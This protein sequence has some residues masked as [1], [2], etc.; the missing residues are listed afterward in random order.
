M[1]WHYVLEHDSTIGIFWF[2]GCKCSFRPERVR[3]H[4]TSVGMVLPMKDSIAFLFNEL[5]EVGNQLVDT[6]DFI[7]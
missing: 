5:I 6:K 3:Q 2:S 1:L 4:Q 7:S